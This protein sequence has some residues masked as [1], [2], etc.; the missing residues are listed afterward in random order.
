MDCTANQ[1]T[2][3]K[4]DVSGYPTLKI[5][6]NGDFSS[7]YQGP[8]EAGKFRLLFID[9]RMTDIIQDC[10]YTLKTYFSIAYSHDMCMVCK[11]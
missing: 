5:F 10:H 2:C 1:D 11:G 4:Y 9:T 8:R 3:K 6:R 7:D